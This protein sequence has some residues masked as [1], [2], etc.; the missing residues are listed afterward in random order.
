MNGLSL[1]RIGL[2]PVSAATHLTRASV[3]NDN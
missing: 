2:G 1:E 3:L